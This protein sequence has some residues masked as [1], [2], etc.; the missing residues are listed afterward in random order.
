M[1]ARCSIV[2][3]DYKLSFCLFQNNKIPADNTIGRY[4]MELVSNVPQIDAEEF[5]TMLNSNMK[6]SIQINC[7]TRT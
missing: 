6:V 2:F 4:L 1:Q 5:E 3:K 7:C